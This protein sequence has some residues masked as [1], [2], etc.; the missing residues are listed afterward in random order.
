MGSQLVSYTGQI[1]GNRWCTM[2]SKRKY[3]FHANKN[4]EIRFDCWIVFLANVEYGSHELAS[5]Q[6]NST[7]KPTTHNNPRAAIGCLQKHDD[8]YALLADD[9]RT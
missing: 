7:T 8:K 1:K 3:A 6:E 9:G 4:R 2:G 5:A